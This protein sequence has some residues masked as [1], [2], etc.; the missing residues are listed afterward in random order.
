MQRNQEEGNRD[1]VDEKENNNKI[2]K[3]NYCYFT[4]TR[5]FFSSSFWFTPAR[6]VKQVAKLVEWTVQIK[7]FSSFSG[8]K[9]LKFS[10][11]NA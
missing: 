1:K 6:C 2:N 3:L 10:A 4:S 8:A 11:I 7:F 5:L 9:I